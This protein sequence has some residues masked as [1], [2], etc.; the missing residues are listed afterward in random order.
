MAMKR[1]VSEY[2]QHQKD[3]NYF[4]SVCPDEDNFLKWN[5]IMVGPPDSLYEHGMFGGYIDFPKTYPIKPPQVT[6]N[7]NIFHP[8]VYVDGKVCITI[9]HEGVDQFGYE[10]SMERWNPSHGVE[11]IMISINSMLG[12]PNYESPANPTIAKMARENKE[13]LEKKIFDLVLKSQS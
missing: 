6:F 10:S 8:N 9:L 12:D 11:S 5:F 7:T 3:P 2:K 4:Y 1:L 13:E